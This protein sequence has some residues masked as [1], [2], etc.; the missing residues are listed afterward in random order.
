M[1]AQPIGLL[2]FREG[3]VYRREELGD[4]VSREEVVAV[5]LE[6]C[7]TVGPLAAARLRQRGV[8]ARCVE[9]WQPRRS[10]LQLA[11]GDEGLAVDAD[12]ADTIIKVLRRIEDGDI[13]N[14]PALSP[15]S[16]VRIVTNDAVFRKLIPAES[17]AAHRP[18]IS[19][20]Q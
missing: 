3:I 16:D 20:S 8:E 18:A 11:V 15:L 13:K 12:I 5:E 6:E 17:Q 2:F 19:S 1:P 7:R 14:V 10:V 4:A 9:L